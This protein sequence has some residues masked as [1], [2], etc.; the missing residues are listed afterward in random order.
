MSS[1]Q[2]WANRKT[3][4]LSLDGCLSVRVCVVELMKPDRRSRWRENRRDLAGDCKFYQSLGTRSR[5]GDDKPDET[6]YGDRSR[7][8]GR[9]PD[10]IPRPANYFRIFP[11]ADPD[12]VQQP[13][14]LNPRQGSVRLEEIAYFI[15]SSIMEVLHDSLPT[16]ATVS[17]DRFLPASQNICHLHNQTPAD[18]MRSAPK[19]KSEKEKQKYTNNGRA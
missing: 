4:G 5:L 11:V 8:G 17:I 12:T 9:P 2:D 13:L 1:S 19:R 14:N 16:T 15:S 7:I 18:G 3:E 10:I 6:C